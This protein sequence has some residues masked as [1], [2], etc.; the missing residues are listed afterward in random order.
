MNQPMIMQNFLVHTVLPKLV[1]ENKDFDFDL[2][3]QITK[4]HMY[5]HIYIYIIYALARFDM[6]SCVSVFVF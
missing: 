6:S 2:L 5:I 1:K 4:K 3:Q